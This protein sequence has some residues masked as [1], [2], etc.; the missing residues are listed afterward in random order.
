MSTTPELPPEQVVRIPLEQLRESPLNTRRHWNQNKQQDLEQSVRSKGI[1]NPLLVRLGNGDKTSS[2]MG[3]KP[4]YG[5]WWH[6]C[7]R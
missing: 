4:Y 5:P 1:L 2:G 3:L 7:W 6:S